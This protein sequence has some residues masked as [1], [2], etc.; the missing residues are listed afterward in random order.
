MTAAEN[1]ALG[2]REPEQQRLQRQAEELCAESAWLFDQIGIAEGARVLEI[3]CGPR[4]CLDLLSSRA[5][6][7]AASSASSSAPPP[8]NG[9]ETS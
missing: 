5:A 3:G 4:G 8:S 9:R 2:Y 7:R 6:R 1:Y